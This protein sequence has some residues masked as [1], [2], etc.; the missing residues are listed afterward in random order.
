MPPWSRGSS[1]RVRRGHVAIV[2][3]A[4]RPSNR[5]RAMSRLSPSPLCPL[6]TQQTTQQEPAPAGIAP[7]RSCRP[8]PESVRGRPP[9]RARAARLHAA[10]LAPRHPNTVAAHHRPLWRALTPLGPLLRRDHH[11]PCCGYL[12]RS[13]AHK[14][15]TPRHCPSPPLHSLPCTVRR[16]EPCPL[17]LQLTA[18]PCPSSP[19]RVRG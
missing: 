10:N 1:S 18:D 16:A 2:E 7:C 11:G 14:S 12:S 17:P 13:R 8:P 5:P 9:P 15:S 19:R 3:G 4:T 6:S